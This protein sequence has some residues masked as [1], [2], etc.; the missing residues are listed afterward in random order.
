MPIRTTPPKRPV[1]PPKKPEAKPLPKTQLK[2]PS[3]K[4]DATG[5]LQAASDAAGATQTRRGTGRLDLFGVQRSAVRVAARGPASRSGTAG[6]DAFVRAGVNPNAARSLVND[7][8]R[9]RALSIAGAGR[10]QSVRDSL[11]LSNVR[12]AFSGV[13]EGRNT[14]ISRA[15]GRVSALTSG[16][17]ALMAGRSAVR[18]WRSG[19]R[20]QAVTD[21]AS[22]LSSG[23]NAAKA[24]VET[25]KA[26]RAFQTARA[27]IARQLSR[28][29]TT[30]RAAVNRAARRAATAVVN[31]RTERA[32]ARQL[33]PALARGSRSAAT[34]IA[35]TAVRIGARTPLAAQG[36]V[37][38]RVIKPLRRAAA[39]V[40]GALRRPLG[41][42][43]ATT[44]GRTLV[45]NGARVA[46]KAGGR[47]VP[48]MNVVIAAADTATAVQTWRDPKA[49][50][51]KKVTA[52]ITA[53]GSIAAATNIPVVSQV[54]AGVSAVSSFVGGLFG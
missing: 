21:G 29:P 51:G 17:N 35:R 13:A 12:R 19:D 26:S 25:R 8:G 32:V 6:A 11:R 5:L 34:P 18:A 14:T 24:T 31:G 53:V 4:R 38:K 9:R 27:S 10:S 50:M 1:A 48:G 42:V 36:P 20:N 44:V 23:A 46:A 54:G 43:A 28:Q 37:A 3:T 16:A 33:R 47:F 22:A 52:T 2:A 7:S 40:A 49:S 41:R 39:P 30:S 45:S 15:A